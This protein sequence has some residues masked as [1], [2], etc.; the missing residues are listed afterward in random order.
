M[1]QP[2]IPCW[3]VADEQSQDSPRVTIMRSDGK[4]IIQLFLNKPEAERFITEAGLTGKIPFTIPTIQFLLG[5]IEQLQ[6]SGVEQVYVF[7][8]EKDEFKRAALSIGDFDS[9]IRKQLN[10]N[11]IIR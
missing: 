6:K 9:G 11:Q 8:R 10:K 3:V 1:D 2:L 5:F 7:Y 4:S